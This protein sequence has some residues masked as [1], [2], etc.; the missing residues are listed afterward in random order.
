MDSRTEKDPLG[1]RQVPGDAYYGIQ[2]L[3]GIE[4]FRITGIPI[5]SEPYFIQALGCVKKAAAMANRDLGALD[6]GIAG[7]II[8]ACDRIIAGEFIDQFPSDMIQGGAGTT[9]NMNVNEVIANIALESLGRA[10]GDYQHVSPNDHVNRSQSTNDTYPTAF[11]I[12]LIRRLTSYAQALSRLRDAFS[13]KGREFARV[14]KMGRTHLQDA[15]PMSMGDEFHGFATNLQ[16]ELA[17]IEES[18]HLLSEVNMGATAIGTSINAPPATP[19][20]S[21]GTSAR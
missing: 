15:V 8:G 20:G 9:T 12:A 14:L 18:K 1:E 10:K 3:R 5:S 19:S 11:R 13:E 21:S 2:T 17:R 16:E 6:P 7:A 4:N